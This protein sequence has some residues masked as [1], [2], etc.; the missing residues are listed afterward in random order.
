M[1]NQ[2]KEYFEANK[3]QQPQ[4][5]DIEEK[6]MRRITEMKAALKAEVFHD[7]QEFVKVELRDLEEEAS[8]EGEG[9]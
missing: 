5:Q 7:N 4:Y 9:G 8:Q 2:I 6:V 1:S 3:R